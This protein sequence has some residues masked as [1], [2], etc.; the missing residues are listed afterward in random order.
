MEL[1]VVTL[2]GDDKQV[3][4]PNEVKLGLF[5]RAFFRRGIG[6]PYCCVDGTGACNVDWSN[7]RSC[8][9]CRFD[10]WDDD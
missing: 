6:R 1:S 2:A 9:W 5:F 8:Q 7:R 3:I 4:K 10:R